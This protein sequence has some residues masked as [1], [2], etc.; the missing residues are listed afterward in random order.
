MPHSRM[1]L[2]F[3]IAALPLGLSACFAEEPVSLPDHV[4]DWAAYQG[5][6]SRQPH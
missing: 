6:T 1:R 4:A 5:R 2:L 3:S